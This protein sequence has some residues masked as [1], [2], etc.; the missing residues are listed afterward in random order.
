[1]ELYVTNLFL[2]TFDLNCIFIGQCSQDYQH[3]NNYGGVERVANVHIVIS[4]YIM[5]Q[6]S[7]RD[8]SY[9]YLIP[10]HNWPFAQ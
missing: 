6:A 8:I 10:V 3:Y 4:V 5:V 2:L 9:M 1:M 7:D